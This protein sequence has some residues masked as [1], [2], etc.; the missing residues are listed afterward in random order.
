MSKNIPINDAN[1]DKEN[2]EEINNIGEE[3]SISVDLSPE[4]IEALKKEAAIP[5]EETVSEENEASKE[6]KADPLEVE[7]KKAAEYYDSLLRLK[8]EFENY[9]KR[10]EK[11][12]IRFSVYA[13][14]SILLKFLPTLDNLERSL[15]VEGEDKH[16]LKKIVEGIELIYNE[17]K[18]RLK[19]EGVERMETIGKKFDPYTHEALTVLPSPKHENDTII[20][21]ITPGYTLNG[22]VIR[23]AK[24]IVA[25]NDT[26]KKIIV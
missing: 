3:D 13:K 4:A 9:K 1:K 7:K 17:L 8:A 19:E 23:P 26:E 24:V 25:K 11:E 22:N 5:E 2:K 14:E 6:E 10:M 18:A 16:I 15:K 21:E 12:R 20:E